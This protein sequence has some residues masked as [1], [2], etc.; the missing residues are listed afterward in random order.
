MFLVKRLRYFSKISCLC[1]RYAQPNSF[2]QNRL[3]VGG[4]YVGGDDRYL[5]PLPVTQAGKTRTETA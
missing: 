2:W 1:N 5:R 3:G 4:P